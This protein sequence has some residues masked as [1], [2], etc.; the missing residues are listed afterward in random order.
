MQQDQI[1][2]HWFMHM[3]DTGAIDPINPDL[4][5][6]PENIMSKLYWETLPDGEVIP[7]QTAVTVTYF[8]FISS[9]ITTQIKQ[10]KKIPNE[11]MVTKK[12]LFNAVERFLTLA[13]LETLKRAG[14]LRYQ[15]NGAWHDEMADIIVSDL[16][17]FSAEA[18]NS[19]W[20]NTSFYRN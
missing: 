12:K 4:S 15:T 20:L 7:T 18:A 19:Q 9:K 10:N 2:L 11:L 14:I 6:V 16:R 5:L 1:T 13:N 8:L 17:P 3:V